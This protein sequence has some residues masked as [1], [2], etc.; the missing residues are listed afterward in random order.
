MVKLSANKIIILLHRKIN[1]LMTDV[2]KIY[3]EQF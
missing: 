2:L 3:F 1:K